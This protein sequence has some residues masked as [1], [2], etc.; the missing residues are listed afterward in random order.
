M[1]TDSVLL[2]IARI[3]GLPFDVVEQ[4]FRGGNVEAN[5][6]TFN[7]VSV[8]IAPNWGH[9]LFVSNVTGTG[10]VVSPGHVYIRVGESELAVEADAIRRALNAVREGTNTKNEGDDQW[11]W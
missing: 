7:S 3:S 4:K 11:G 1:V 5:G 10:T 9:P 8:Q 2:E 6:N